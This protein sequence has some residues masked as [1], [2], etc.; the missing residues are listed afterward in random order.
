M[1]GDGGDGGGAVLGIILIFFTTS[2]SAS[3]RCGFFLVSASDGLPRATY[4]VVQQHFPAVC[5]AKIFRTRNMEKEC[6]TQVSR[7]RWSGDS[8]VN[9]ILRVK[10]GVPSGLLSKE[11]RGGVME[12]VFAR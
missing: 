4:F 8:R 1:G 3:W 7:G 10:T 12:T 5:P 2:N 11:E 6:K 9:I